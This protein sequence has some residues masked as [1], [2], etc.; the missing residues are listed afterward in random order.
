MRYKKP[1]EFFSGF[2]IDKGD[3]IKIKGEDGGNSKKYIHNCSSSRILAGGKPYTTFWNCAF[4]GSRRINEKNNT[5]NNSIHH[6]LFFV[7]LVDSYSDV[8][9]C[10]S[11]WSGRIDAGKDNVR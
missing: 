10:V 1:G 6:Y 2:C 11:V 8:G 7:V 4:Y 5:I 3:M 9:R